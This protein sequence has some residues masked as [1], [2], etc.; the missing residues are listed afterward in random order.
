MLWQF[1]EKPCFSANCRLYTDVLAQF[2][3]DKCLN[4]EEKQ[5]SHFLLFG[6]KKYMDEL[7]Q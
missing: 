1:A 2:K 4:C 5:K 6:W 7:F 3:H